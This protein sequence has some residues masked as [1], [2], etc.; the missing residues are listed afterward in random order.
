MEIKNKVADWLQKNG[1]PLEMHVAKTFSR[2]GF[3]VE[4]SDYFY[5]EESSD[6]RELDI[7]AKIEKETDVVC[8]SVNFLIECKYCI[9]HPWVVFKNKKDEVVSYTLMTMSGNTLGHKMAFNY[10]WHKEIRKLPV[11]CNHKSIGYAAVE[12]LRNSEKK[13]NCYSAFM[14]IS[15]AINSYSKKPKYTHAA[16]KQLSTIFV[17]IIV[18]KGLLFEAYLNEQD[19]IETRNATS[20]TVSWDNPICG[21]QSAIIH[22]VTQDFLEKFCKSAKSSATKLLDIVISDGKI[23]KLAMA[24]AKKSKK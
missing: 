24:N 1:Y 7:I 8:Y 20:S 13:D 18:I 15:K 16:G 5:D 12:A 22:I 3:N 17:P 14:A 19:E 23:D 21:N 9:E 11:L 2:A 10:S 4:Q 6:Y